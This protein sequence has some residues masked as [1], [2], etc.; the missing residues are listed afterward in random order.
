MEIKKG[1]IILMYA[2]VLSSNVFAIERHIQYRRGHGQDST[3]DIKCGAQKVENKYA[4][5]KIPLDDE[6]EICHGLE[7]DWLL[8]KR[9]DDGYHYIEKK[10]VVEI[11]KPPIQVNYSFYWSL[12][13]LFDVGANLQI[14]LTSPATWS[15]LSI[16][17]LDTVKDDLKESE[18]YPKMYHLYFRSDSDK[19]GVDTYTPDGGWKHIGLTTQPCPVKYGKTYNITLESHSGFIRTRIDG[20]PYFD[21]PHVTPPRN[22]ATLAINTAVPPPLLVHNISM[23]G[24][25]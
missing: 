16:N 23:N 2:E 12:P 18:L 4:A 21:L 11:F 19:A 10:K 5:V 14:Y 25:V 20:Q 9:Y 13:S 7:R 17:L 1:I 8:D 22:A 15:R 3:N 6:S 24:R